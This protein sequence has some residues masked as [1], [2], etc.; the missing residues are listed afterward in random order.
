ME[1]QGRVRDVTDSF[2]DY[3]P[4]VPILNASLSQ[5]VSDH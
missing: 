4:R 2:S 1:L 3:K 5:N